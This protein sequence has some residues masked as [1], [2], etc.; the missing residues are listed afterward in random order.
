MPLKKKLFFSCMDKMIQISK[1][2]SEKCE[3]EI[4]FDKCDPEK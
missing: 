4:I 1:E 2:E 3:V